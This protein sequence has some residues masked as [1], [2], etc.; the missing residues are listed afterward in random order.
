VLDLTTRR[1]VL[2]ALAGTIP[3]GV[4]AG[5]SGGDG[6]DGADE[7][8]T[9]TETEMP[10]STPTPTPEPQEETVLAGPDAMNVFEPDSLEIS[11]GTVVTFV[12]ESGGH[13]LVVGSHPDGAD[14]GGVSETQSAGYEHSHTFEVAG[15]YKYHCGPHQSFGMEGSITVTE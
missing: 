14:W 8:D 11:T 3:V 9:P 6:G 2:R 13:S 15:T 1:Q 7:T 10:T 12:W 4:L 5:C